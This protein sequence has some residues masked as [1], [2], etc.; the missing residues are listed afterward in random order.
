MGAKVTFKIVRK[1]DGS[2]NDPGVPFT[3][4]SA[5]DFKPQY[6]TG[7]IMFVEDE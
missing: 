2:F 4:E 6:S 1:D 5:K 3:K 7:Q